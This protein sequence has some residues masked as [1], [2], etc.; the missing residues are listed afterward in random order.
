MNVPEPRQVLVSRPTFAELAAAVGKAGGSDL[1]D[2]DGNIHFGTVTIIA[3]PDASQAAR[4]AAA[5]SDATIPS[6]AEQNGIIYEG[7]QV[8]ILSR[9]KHDGTHLIER[10]PGCDDHI[11]VIPKQALH[12]VAGDLIDCMSKPII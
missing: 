6:E 2:E 3:D 8:T 12:L 1:L 11:V 4:L 9:C 7:D 5:I 10:R